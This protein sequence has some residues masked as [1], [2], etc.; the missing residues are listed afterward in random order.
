V[1][2][3]DRWWRP[4]GAPESASEAVLGAGLTNRL[5]LDCTVDWHRLVIEQ[6]AALD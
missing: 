3:C 2:I 6:A 4:L 1:R 5:A